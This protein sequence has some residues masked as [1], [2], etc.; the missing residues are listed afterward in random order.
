MNTTIN[1]APAP[2]VFH[3]QELPVAVI[4]KDGDPWFVASEVC[5]ALELQN[6]RMALRRLDPDEKGVSKIYTLGGEQEISI[7]SEPGLYRLASRSNKP[8]AHRFIRWVAHDVLPA[9]RKTG[10][11][12]AI[13]PNPTPDDAHE[14]LTPQDMMTI[15]R[16]VWLICQGMWFERGWV[17]AVWS[18]LREATGT[19]A[20]N[21]FHVRHLPIIADELRRIFRLAESFK[22]AERQAGQLLVKRVLRNGEEAAPI[23]AEAQRLMSETAAADESALNQQMERWQEAELA[24]LTDR[25]PAR[26]C[27]SVIA[28]YGENQHSEESFHA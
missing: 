10:S 17:K 2:A 13:D 19:K 14:Y 24:A 20:P 4:L 23:L 8:A 27:G 22:A 5:R 11:Y 7:I 25:K 28:S 9:I 18:R 15:T 1:G 16:I 21:R 12:S 6:S 26:L 3:F